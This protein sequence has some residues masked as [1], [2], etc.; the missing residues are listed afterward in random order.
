MGAMQGTT[1]ET[2]YIVTLK[3]ILFL[4]IFMP[5]LTSILK[6]ELILGTFK[7]RNKLILA[8]NSSVFQASPLIFAKL[9]NL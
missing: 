6:I 8:W 4:E 3:P 2:H 5:Y 7:A 1:F 9:Q